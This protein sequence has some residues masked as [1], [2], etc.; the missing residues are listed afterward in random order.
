MKIESKV[1]IWSIVEKIN[2]VHIKLNRFANLYSKQL[3]NQCKN[4][5]KN[6]WKFTLKTGTAME[7]LSVQKSGKPKKRFNY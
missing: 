6:T 1:F 4:N 3:G 7:F 2:F 5:E